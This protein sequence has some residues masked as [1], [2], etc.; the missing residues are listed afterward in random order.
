M[1]RLLVATVLALT[2]TTL[3]PAQEADDRPVSFRGLRDASMF[4]LIDQIAQQL[5]I[6]YMIDP[7]VSDG[8]IT[9]NTYGDMQRSDL[10]PLLQTILRMNGAAAVEVED[11]W[12]IIP[13]SGVAQAPISPLSTRSPDELPLAERMVLNAIRLNYMAAED[14]SAV[15]APFLGVGGQFAVV[16]QANT[17]ILL[18][19]ARNMRRTLNLIALFDTEEMANQRMRLIEIEN[20]LA[21]TVAEE[22][23]SVFGALSSDGD[24]SAIQFVPL[25][26]IS[27]VLV[28]S[29][30]PQIFDQVEEWVKR[31][32]KAATIGGVQNFVYKVQ[33]GFATSLAQTLLQLYGVQGGYGGY[34]GGSGGFGGGYGGYGGGY[35]GGRG[36]GYPGGG[37]YSYGGGRGGGG[38]GGYGGGFGGGY[39]GGFIQLPGAVQQVLPQT[40]IAG[41]TDQTGALLGD[42]ATG[43]QPQSGIRIVPDFVNNLIVVQSTKQEWEVIHKTLQELDFPPRQVLI[44][45]QIYEVSL[46]GGLEMG[47]SAFLRERRGE[48]LT[49]TGS[50][51]NG[52]LRLTMGTLVGNTRELVAFLNA[53]QTTGRTRIISA[54]TL[55][56]TDNLSASITVGQ[57]IP[58]LTSQSVGDVQI[59]GDSQ[60]TQTITNVQTGVTLSITPRVNASGIVTMQIQQEVSSPQAPTGSIDSPSIDRRSVQTQVT[61]ADGDTVAIGG[62]I[63]ETNLFGRSAVPVLGKIPVLGALFGTTTRSTSKTELIILL[64]PRVIYDETE[65]VSASNDLIDRMKKLRSIMRD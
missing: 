10:M 42:V 40:G 65:I 38:Y 55:L 19:N 1:K 30:S 20:S 41:G 21:S 27:S 44:D 14:L 46:K 56:A 11:V 9:I 43:T 47:V 34:G 54:P 13:L 36:G 32:D 53:S 45:A 49:T 25:S 26:R 35:D 7:A 4:D 2:L 18:D 15:L 3:V 61:V 24:E 31:L 5:G 50:I 58:I 23:R 51:V 64:T 22:L 17:L 57:S 8:T 48:P 59:G 63:Q 29:S 52:A 33:Y 60:F 12:R 16:S 62:I 37:G 6:N 39:G 28:V